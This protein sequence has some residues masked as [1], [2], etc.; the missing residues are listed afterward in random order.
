VLEDETGM[1]QAIFM[2]DVFEAARRTIVDAP[3]MVIEGVLQKLDGSLSVKAERAW[4]LEKLSPTPSHD[5][6]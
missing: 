3:G 2:P 6:R 5:F 4:P 1:A